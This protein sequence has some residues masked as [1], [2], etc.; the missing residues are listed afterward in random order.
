MEELKSQ[1][2]IKHYGFSFHAGPDLLEKVL[3]THPEVDFVQLQINYADWEDKGVQ[4]R[5]NYEV[6]RKHDKDIIVMEPVKGGKLANPP[7]K[8]QELFKSANP[9]ASYAS[10][11]LRFAASLEGVKVVLSG[12][13]NLEQMQ[14]NLSFMKDFQ[15]LTSDEWQVI[16]KAQT[17]MGKIGG[18]PCTACGYCLGECPEEIPIPEVFNAMN[19]RI[20]NSQEEQSRIAYEKLA[21]E[22]PV[23][24]DCIDCGAC[25]KVC[26]Q[27]IDIPA[28]MKE[29]QAFYA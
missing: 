12:M 14:D 9:N 6:A 3:R 25:A 27:H 26:P 4:A 7:K 15:P 8:V 24:Q 29:Q 19:L 13:S 16:R 28:L 1:G 11:A 10:W 2:K 22:G 17:E 20:A 23:A 18:I 5:K 21:N